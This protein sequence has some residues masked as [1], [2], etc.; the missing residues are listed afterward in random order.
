MD[1]RVANN[2]KKRALY[3][4]RKK[5]HQCVKCGSTDKRTQSGLTL[6]RLCAKIERSYS[7][8]YAQSDKGK[9][10]QRKAIKAYYH[11]RKG[12]GLCVRCGE[13]V[14]IS[15][16]RSTYCSKCIRKTHE[17][18][19]LTPEDVALAQLLGGIFEKK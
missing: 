16:T 13:P 1:K 2:E 14:D 18:R 6:C 3:A 15:E 5:N 10:S 12:L 11:K 9:E 7:I 8:K 17:E 4:E 19:S